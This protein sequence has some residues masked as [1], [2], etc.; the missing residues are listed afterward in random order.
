MGGCP[1][2][3]HCPA[4][5]GVGHLAGRARGP[6]S[7]GVRGWSGGLRGRCHGNVNASSFLLCLCLLACVPSFFSLWRRARACGSR[8]C[9][10][11]SSVALSRCFDLPSSFR[12][13][14]D[15]SSPSTVLWCIRA[16]SE[17]GLKSGWTAAGHSAAGCRQPFPVGRSPGTLSRRSRA[18]QRMRGASC[19][20][21]GCAPAHPT[22]ATVPD[23]AK[24][25]VKFVLK[26]LCG[27]SCLSVRA[28][29]SVSRKCRC[30]RL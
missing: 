5:G 25:F 30:S 27:A 26:R 7:R 3:G 8:S 17:H 6:G 21:P 1:L 11:F 29:R 2:G 14:Q 23:V 4:A 15:E 13:H 12:R 18:T 24:L 16:F 10:S 20:E 19:Q 22:Q 28:R 9:R